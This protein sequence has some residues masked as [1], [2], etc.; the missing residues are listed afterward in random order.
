MGREH[1][2]WSALSMDVG[3]NAEGRTPLDIVVASKLTT[4][5]GMDPSTWSWITGSIQMDTMQTACKI[6]SAEAFTLWSDS[7]VNLGYVVQTNFV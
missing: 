7:R 5:Q 6:V 2:R 1:T 4:L 3:W